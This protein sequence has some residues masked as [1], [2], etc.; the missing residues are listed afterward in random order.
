MVAVGCHGSSHAS[1]PGTPSEL[2]PTAGSPPTTSVAPTPSPP[3]GPL[4][5]VV[6]VLE[7]HEYGS[8]IGSSE[9]PYL[10][11]LAR[12]SVLLTDYHA[13]SHPSLPNY[14]ALLGGSTFGITSDCTSCDASGANVVDQLESKGIGWRAYMEGMPK[15]CFTGPDYGT[16]AKKHDPFL[17]FP[18]IREDPARC[19]RV[20]PFGRFAPDL[21]AGDVPPFAWITPDLCHDAHDCPL[22]AADGWLRDWVPRIVTALAPEVAVVV[23]F[24]EGT[25]DE[26]CCGN[27]AGGHVLA[28]IAGPAARSGVRITAPV[29]HYSMLRLIEDFWGLPHLRQAA[30]PCTASI[31]GWRA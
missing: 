15:P 13:V 20:V 29:D 31:A 14:L 7:N 10:N 21:S 12:R 9:A 27:A 3:I 8:V 5:L 30:C 4:H 2:P 24:D 23:V 11:G 28:L 25:T 19:A 26:G 22:S 6:I 16:Y 17:Y 18:D 1:S